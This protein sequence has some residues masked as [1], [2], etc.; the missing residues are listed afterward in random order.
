LGTI[1]AGAMI[2]TCYRPTSG[3][4]VSNDVGVFTQPRA[5]VK[6]ISK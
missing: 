5:G 4:K 2:H 6:L 3:V 1:Q